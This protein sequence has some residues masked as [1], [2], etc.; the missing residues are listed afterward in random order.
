MELPQLIKQEANYS[1]SKS[2]V[3]PLKNHSRNPLWPYASATIRSAF[4]STA[5]FCTSSPTVQPEA[6]VSHAIRT[7]PDG[8]VFDDARLARD[9]VSV[10]GSRTGDGTSGG[11]TAH[12]GDVMRLFAR[13]YTSKEIAHQL[14]MTATSAEKHKARAVQKFEL[15]NRAGIVQGWFAKA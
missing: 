6:V 11:L 4:I 13:G 15:P 3:T 9:L 2:R 1:P 12:K 5:A 7:V 8:G 14:G 10:R